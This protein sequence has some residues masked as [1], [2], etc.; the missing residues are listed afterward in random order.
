[1]IRYKAYLN[2]KLNAIIRD[3]ISVQIQINSMHVKVG[4]SQS[5]NRSQ[6]SG[7]TNAQFIL[8]ELII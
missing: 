2:C 8:Y 4:Q 1:M 6:M 3:K 7:L 5:N